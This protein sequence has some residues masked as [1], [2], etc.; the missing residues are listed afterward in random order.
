M[1][2]MSPVNRGGEEVGIK[3]LMSKLLGMLDPIVCV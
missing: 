1:K 3:K 2:L